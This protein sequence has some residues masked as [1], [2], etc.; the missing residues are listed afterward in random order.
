MGSVITF[1]CALNVAK[2]KI[3]GGSFAEKW[4][5]V[6]KSQFQCRFVAEKGFPGVFAVSLFVD[7]LGVL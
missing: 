2:L 1:P 5:Q 7:A 3:L 4:K 6:L